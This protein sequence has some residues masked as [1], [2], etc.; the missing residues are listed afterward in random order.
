MIY[1]SFISLEEKKTLS[2]L[3]KRQQYPETLQVLIHGVRHLIKNYT[4]RKKK[5]KKRP[6]SKIPRGKIDTQEM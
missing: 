4:A 5:K 6:N 3:G 2:L 1:W